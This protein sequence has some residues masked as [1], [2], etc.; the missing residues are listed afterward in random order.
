MKIKSK[1]KYVV[2]YYER[3]LCFEGNKIQFLNNEEL[4]QFIIENYKKLNYIFKNEPIKWEKNV[5]IKIL[6]EK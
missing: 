5:E 2:L 4:T 1:D 6:E 3:N